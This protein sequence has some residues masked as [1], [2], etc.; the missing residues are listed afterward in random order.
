MFIRARWYAL[1]CALG[2]IATA[3][4]VIAIQEWWS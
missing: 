1:L 4:I 2:A 3:W